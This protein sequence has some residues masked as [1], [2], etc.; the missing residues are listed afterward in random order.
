[1]HNTLIVHWFIP[2]ISPGY[3][4]F[5]MSTNGLIHNC[6]P[7]GINVTLSYKKHSLSKFVKE[8]VELND[9]STP[10]YIHI[11]HHKNTLNSI[12]NY[13]KNTTIHIC[14]LYVYE[15]NYFDS[16]SYK[17]YFKSLFLQLKD[18]YEEEFFQLLKSFS[19]YPKSYSIIHIRM[20]DKYI[21]SKF[22]VPS[23]KIK[24]LEHAMNELMPII[25][26]EK[27][28][29]LLSNCNQIKEF[30]IKKYKCIALSI[31]TQCHSSVFD[32][33]SCTAQRALKYTLF[34]FK[35]IEYAHSVYSIPMI[36]SK[37]DRIL[38]GGNFSQFA[39]QIYD[40]PYYLF[41]FIPIYEKYHDVQTESMDSLEN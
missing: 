29:L 17:C 5:L 18:V 13:H 22:S 27:Q 40:I 39:C 19:L 4:S 38:H 28:I 21:Y 16:L 34:D 9:F 31:D 26:I 33:L 15:Q 8:Q 10:P 23:R 12:L 37:K 11:I 2:N 25:G 24:Y 20:H 32:M 14:C 30:F 7:L 36:Y 6:L 3:V 35:A 41:N 1:M